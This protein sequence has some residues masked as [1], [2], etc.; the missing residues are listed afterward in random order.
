MSSRTHKPYVVEFADRA[1]AS[2]GCGVDNAFGMWLERRGAWSWAHKGWP[3]RDAAFVRYEDLIDGR[4]RAAVMAELLRA[5]G[6]PAGAGA[7][8]ALPAHRARASAL[9]RVHRTPVEGLIEA[10]GVGAVMWQIVGDV[11]PAFGY[12]RFS[13]VDVPG[14]SPAAQRARRRQAMA[15][16]AAPPPLHVNA[17]LSRLRVRRDA[18]RSRSVESRG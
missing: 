17:P 12:E 10:G 5:V 18:N 14:A 6:M 11:A 3:A 13:Y 2:P 16:A 9:R 15:L 1:R 4:R 8:P 7:A